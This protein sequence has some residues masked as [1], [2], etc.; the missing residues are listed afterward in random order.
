MVGRN[1]GEEGDGGQGAASE[2]GGSR[3]GE[4]GSDGKARE[5]GHTSSLAESG[6]DRQAAAEVQ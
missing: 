2:G 6:L 1:I 3:E 5:G 4:G